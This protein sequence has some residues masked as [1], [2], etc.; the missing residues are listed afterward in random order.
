MSDQ[1][2][3]AL[4]QVRTLLRD[5]SFTPERIGDALVHGLY[6]RLSAGAQTTFEQ[7]GRGVIF[8]DLRDLAAGHLDTSYI[9]LALLLR[10]DTTDTPMADALALAEL[11]DPERE[12][13]VVVVHPEQVLVYRLNLL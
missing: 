7:L 13:V 6:P 10:A 9:P 8:A 2:H 12:F 11:Y 4:D 5:G 3:P 1:P